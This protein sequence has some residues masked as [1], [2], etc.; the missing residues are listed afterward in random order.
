MDGPLLGEE[1]KSPG[2]ALSPLRQSQAIKVDEAFSKLL[3]S[4][5]IWLEFSVT[6]SG[7]GIAADD[8]RTLFN[9]FTQIRAGDLQMGRGSGLGLCICKHMVQMLQGRIGVRS[10]PKVGSCFF[11]RMPFAIH[12]DDYSY[13]TTSSS[14]VQGPSLLQSHSLTS[15]MQRPTFNH[16]G[17]AHQ[18]MP[19]TSSGIEPLDR[20]SILSTSQVSSRPLS[21]SFDV[22]SSTQKEVVESGTRILIVDDVTTNRKMIRRCVQQLG[23]E[24]DLA[25]NGR[26]AVEM[27]EKATLMGNT[28]D[29]NGYSL[30][31]MD[32][33]MPNMTGVE[34]TEK[35]RQLERHIVAE[36]E[37]SIGRIA[38]TSSPRFHTRG[39]ALIFGLTGNAL[40]E[41][42]AEF[43]NAGCDE[44]RERFILYKRILEII[45]LSNAWLK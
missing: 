7:C 32:N 26:E 25:E 22:G 14:Q 23:F 39:R 37:T 38:S 41:D 31:L 1:Q 4:D 33:V 24:C 40:S 10:C 21:S 11:F 29:S 13:A 16:R 44:V 17:T 18:D 36:N 15:A 28:G 43:K 6:D 3:S 20:S 5:S 8:M 2:A 9:A 42:V 34:A 27:W 45:I 19:H 30:I 12:T 35:I